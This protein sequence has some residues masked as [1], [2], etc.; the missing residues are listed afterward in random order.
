MHFSSRFF[1]KNIFLSRPI[2]P[3]IIFRGHEMTTQSSDIQRLLGEKEHLKKEEEAL[4]SMIE[5]VK[6]QISAIQ[7][8]QLQITSRQPIST[9]PALEPV[10]QTEYKPQKKEEL[11]G[12]DI[13]IPELDLDILG[14][15]HSRPFARNQGEEEVEEEDE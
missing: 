8:E 10:T 6:K 2:P 13:S 9:F 7:V 4:R 3:L 1:G 11:E 14:N 12:P 15:L 5:K